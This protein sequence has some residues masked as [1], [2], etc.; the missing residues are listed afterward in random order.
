MSVSQEKPLVISVCGT[1]LKPEMLSVYRQVTGLTRWRTE[2]YCEERINAE[3][4]P[5]SPLTVMRKNKF[6]PRGNF[7]RRF[8]VK[9]VL[10]TWP[11]PGEEARYLPPLGWHSHNLAPLLAKA[12]PHL[13]H[14]YYG[15]KAAKFLPMIQ[16]WGGPLI[17][18]FH[19]VDTTDGAYKDEYAHALPEVFTTATL[20]LARSQSLLDRVLEMGCPPEKLRLNRTPIPLEGIIRRVRT[21]PANGG[22]IFLQACRLIAKKGL[23]TAVEAFAIF[24]KEHPRAQFQIAGE[25][26]QRKALEEKIAALGLQENVKLLGWVS[27]EEL[28]RRIDAAH[29]FLHPSEMTASGDREGVP[30]AMLEAMAAGLPVVATDHGGIPEAVTNG[31]D[32]LLVAERSPQELAA[33]LLEITKEAAQYG[34]FSRKAMVNIERSYGLPQ[35]LA[36]LESCYDEA[37]ALCREPV[38]A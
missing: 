24:Q 9:H 22:W 16:A 33:A 26:P 20:V 35:S 6:R 3:K 21:V 31:E 5:F 7:L 13:L 37:I 11:P 23:L 27:S 10:K 38:P 30:N 14:V 1:F 28:Y 32:G 18:S 8:W 2:L 34:E 29:L 36:A 4:F 19:G 15:H 12:K 17:V 25:G